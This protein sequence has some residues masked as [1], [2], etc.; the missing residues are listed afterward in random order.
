[1]CSVCVYLVEVV[2]NVECSQLGE[3]SVKAEGHKEA[4]IFIRQLRVLWL[5]VSDP[6][7]V[8]LE[9]KE[10]DP[11]MHVTGIHLSGTSSE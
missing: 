2:M 4:C 6:G 1:M 10:F 7:R 8:H 3:M 5:V 11:L 9:R